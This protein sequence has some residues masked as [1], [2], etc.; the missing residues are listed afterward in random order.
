[1]HN[2]SS[3]RLISHTVNLRPGH[4]FCIFH[5]ESF[6]A[7]L[8]WSE[9]LLILAT[10]ATVRPL[11]AIA[12][13]YFTVLQVVVMYT[14]NRYNR[15]NLFRL[16]TSVLTGVFL[17]FNGFVAY[18]SNIIL[19]FRGCFFSKEMF[20]LINFFAQ[21]IIPCLVFLRKKGTPL[22]FQAAFSAMGA[23]P[24]KSKIKMNFPENVCNLLSSS[25]VLFYLRVDTF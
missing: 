10:L 22:Q 20:I 1:M 15:I 7:I 9:G 12:I 11:H 18:F 4:S 16:A 19:L 2:D 3:Q 8:A 6:R 21:D 17:L 5:K 25:T 14:K 13:S 23:L 24:L